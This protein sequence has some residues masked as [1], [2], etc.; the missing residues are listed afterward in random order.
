[1]MH[2]PDSA[3]VEQ[4]HTVENVISV[5]LVSGISPIVSAASAMGMQMY[6]TL[7]QGLASVAD[8]QH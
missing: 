4:I 1:V 7:G 3:S 8:I 5:S 6:V 2:R